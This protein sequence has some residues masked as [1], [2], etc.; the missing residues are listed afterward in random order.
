MYTSDA[1]KAACMVSGG[2]AWHTPYDVTDAQHYYSEDYTNQA[3]LASILQPFLLLHGYTTGHLPFRSSAQH[4][5][6]TQAKSPA[7]T[8]KKATIHPTSLKEA[9][10]PLALPN[11]NQS[12]KQFTLISSCLNIPSPSPVCTALPTAVV[13]C[14]TSAA[15]VPFGPSTPSTS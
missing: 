4:R 10:S 9:L 11:T 13:L 15:L 3:A 8:A 2:S 6:N 5:T 1:F 7:P 12:V 14:A